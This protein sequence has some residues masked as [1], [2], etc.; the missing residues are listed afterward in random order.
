MEKEKEN[1]IAG[2]WKAS[3]TQY[4]EAL[5]LWKILVFI[6]NITEEISRV[7]MAKVAR[8]NVVN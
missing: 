2:R 7:G 8:M 1:N 3:K 4:V 6:R 5:P